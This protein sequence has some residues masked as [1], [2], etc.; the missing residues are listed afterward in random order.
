MKVLFCGDRNWTSA[1]SIRRELEQLPPDT[2]IIDG[3]ARGADSIA[4][5]EAQKL[6]LKSERYPALWGIYGRSAGPR[7]NEQMLQ[8]GKP[9]LVFAFHKNLEESRGTKHMVTIARKA[10]VEVKVITR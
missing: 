1:K 2:V 10:G 5:Y 4:F 9:D 8:E 6:G 3:M 7:R